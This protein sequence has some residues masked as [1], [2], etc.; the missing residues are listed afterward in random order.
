VFLDYQDPYSTCLIICDDGVGK[1]EINQGYDLLG[2]R[3]RA[4][5]LGGEVSIETR[6]GKG[7]SFMITIPL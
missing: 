7:F 5:L 4:H 1:E 6:P 2:I 3:E